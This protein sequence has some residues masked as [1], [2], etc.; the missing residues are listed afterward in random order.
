M[1]VEL[2]VIEPECDWYILTVDGKEV[3]TGHEI[4]D[5]VWIEVLK[6]AGI[7]VTEKR[8]L[9]HFLGVCGDECAECDK[10]VLVEWGQDT[11]RELAE[12]FFNPDD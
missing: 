3:H 8:V 10:E 7:K 6:S 11:E 1:K 2:T 12:E 9:A 5:F 4:P